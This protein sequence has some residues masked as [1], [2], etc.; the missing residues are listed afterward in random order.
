LLVEMQAKPRDF[1]GPD[2]PALAR[3]L[4][5]HSK[6][7]FAAQ[8]LLSLIDRPLAIASRLEEWSRMSVQ[9]L[10]AKSD[11]FPSRLRLS[12]VPPPILFATGNLELLK[13]RLVYLPASAGPQSR[14]PERNALMEMLGADG[15]AM[16]SGWPAV[17]AQ[18][19][20]ELGELRL[21]V[22]ILEQRG[23]QASRLAPENRAWLRDGRM[24]AISVVEP[25]HSDPFVHDIAFTAANAIAI[26]RTFK[27]RNSLRDAFERADL[28]GTALF[29]VADATGA[30]P[31]KALT[32]KFGFRL[33]QGTPP[34][35]TELP[36][37]DAISLSLPRTEEAGKPRTP[38]A[39][40]EL[41]AFENVT[42][43]SIP[44]TLPTVLPEAESLA[45]DAE[46]SSSS[47]FD[48]ALQPCPESL[49]IQEVRAENER[50][51]SVTI[52]EAVLSL[53]SRGPQKIR[54]LAK[55]LGLKEGEAKSV[56]DS[57]CDEKR[58]VKTGDHFWVPAANVMPREERS[59]DL[60]SLFDG[61][62]G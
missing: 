20:R 13:G 2:A 62:D 36:L 3:E 19:L 60:L 31:D 4:A 10:G 43:A 46:Q 27:A 56:V 40:E 12:R 41:P 14:V 25:E 51:L 47:A 54:A 11:G 44:P 42:D 6:G 22:V 21:P 16:L 18:M 52:D 38:S 32:E 35:L 17:S 59:G 50:R 5:Q 45:A 7:R 39:A 30:A 24:A 55:L 28:G 58:L 49:K 23:L 15:V 34:A 37:V 1:F 33:F 48:H 9:P 8:R 29:A 57:L 53:L 26:S 61:V